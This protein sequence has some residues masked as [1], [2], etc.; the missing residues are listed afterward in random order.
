M[1]KVHLFISPCIN[2]CKKQVQISCT[3]NVLKVCFFEHVILFGNVLEM[4]FWKLRMF[5][6]WHC[7]LNVLLWAFLIMWLSGQVG[8]RLGFEFQ[9]SFRVEQVLCGYF[10]RI[11]SFFMRMVVLFCRFHLYTCV[12]QENILQELQE[13]YVFI[14]VGTY[15]NL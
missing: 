11:T 8:S 2:P 7:T 12:M 5:A 13:R 4:Y 1:H 10:F 15:R 6:N 9:L 3:W 14:N